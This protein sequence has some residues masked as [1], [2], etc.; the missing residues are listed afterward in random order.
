MT[1]VRAGPFSAAISIDNQLY[2]WG[3]GAFGEFYTPHRVKSVQA[4]DFVDVQIG[5]GGYL[6]LLTRQG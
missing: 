1:K 3:C 2:L 6:T 4:L 5:R